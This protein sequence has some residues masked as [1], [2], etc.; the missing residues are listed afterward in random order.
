MKV[1]LSS[2]NNQGA[3][4]D[5][6]ALAQALRKKY[7]GCQLSIQD[8]EYLKNSMVFSINTDALTGTVPQDKRAIEIET[9]SPELGAS[10]VL[11]CAKLMPKEFSVCLYN[12]SY[13]NCLL[14]TPETREED[15]RH[16]F[17]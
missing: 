10:F 17:E 13:E 7:P 14:L 8:D 12:H 9:E 1:I 11:W 3:E 6:Q 16:R 5:R 2:L 4:I 15:L